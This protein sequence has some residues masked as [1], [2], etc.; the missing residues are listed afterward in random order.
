[1]RE[2]HSKSHRFA[3][4]EAMIESGFPHCL[5]GGADAREG[6]E[7]KDGPKARRLRR[8]PLCGRP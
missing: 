7:V 6:I 2:R 3:T 1:M 4:F 5:H 8:R